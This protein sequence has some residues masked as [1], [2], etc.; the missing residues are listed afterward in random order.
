MQ[1]DERVIPVT[2]STA[3]AEQKQSLWPRFTAMYPDYDNYQR[4]TDRD[5]PIVLLREITQ[6]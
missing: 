1:I 6:S 5:I 4:D 2:A 3:S